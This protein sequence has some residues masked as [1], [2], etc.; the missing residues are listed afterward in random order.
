M[1]LF[2]YYISRIQSDSDH[3]VMFVILL[4][5]AVVGSC[6]WRDENNC[7]TKQHASARGADWHACGAKT[8]SSRVAWLCNNCLPT[9]NALG[10]EHTRV[11][12][13]GADIPVSLSL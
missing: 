5:L 2:I 4:H 3:C 10:A 12:F 9:I 11:S 13:T 1:V 6:Q 7:L 8:A